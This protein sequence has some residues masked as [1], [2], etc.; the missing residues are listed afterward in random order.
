MTHLRFALPIFCAC[1]S[2][3]KELLK[4]AAR[5]VKQGVYV[6]ITLVRDETLTHLI[7]LGQFEVTGYGSK[8]LGLTIK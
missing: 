5:S 1:R 4:D 2:V 8:H 7:G 6:L 3:R